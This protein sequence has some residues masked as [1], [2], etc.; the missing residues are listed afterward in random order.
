MSLIKSYL[1]LLLAFFFISAHPAQAQT[2]SKIGVDYRF[3]INY[4]THLYTLGNIGYNDREYTDK[5]GQYLS[6]EDKD[7]L[8]QH[9]DLLIF[10]Q[11]KTGTLTSFFFFIPSYA[12]LKSYSDYKSY[13][14]DLHTVMDD[15]TIAPLEK[16]LSEDYKKFMGQGIID[17]LKSVRDE[18]DQIADIYLNNIESYRTGVY[19]Q[20]AVELESK[21]K[22]LNS[23]ITGS[24]LMEKWEAV[25][26]Y[27]WNKGDY[28]Y[29]LFR[30]GKNGP[31]FNDLSGNINTCY[32]KIDEEIL[33]DMFSHEFGIFLMFDSVMPIAQQYKKKYPDYESK[34]TVGRP[35]WMAYEMLAVFFNIKVHDRKTFDYYNFKEADPIAFMEIYSDLYNSGIT[36]PVQMYLSGIEEYMKPGGYWNNGVKERY[37]IMT[38]KTDKE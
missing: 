32:Y 33:A 28:T 6:P 7:V 15:N 23:M 4:V 10:G 21:K 27:S 12:D 25:T 17:D 14:T 31:S 5:Y 16:Y 9:K 18:F 26:G 38:G 8:Q 29:L 1:L 11:G 3:G 36:D 19:P 20:V 34:Y 30:A 24:K 35:Y 22:Q 37:E 2:E 13:L